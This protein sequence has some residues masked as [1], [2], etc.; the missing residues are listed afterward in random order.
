MKYDFYD[1]MSMINNFMPY[2]MEQLNNMPN[3]FKSSVSQMNEKI[4]I[5]HYP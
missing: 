1:D 3:D 2:D 4:N 5:T